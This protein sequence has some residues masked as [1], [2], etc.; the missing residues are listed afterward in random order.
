M[1]KPR[2]EGGITTSGYPYLPKENH[3]QRKPTTAVRKANPTSPRRDDTATN[4]SNR[5][6]GVVRA[7]YEHAPQIPK[8][9]ES[10][11]QQA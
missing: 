5:S 7:L 6:N 10:P 4:A 8:G 9:M 11:P 3:V 2:D 1:Y